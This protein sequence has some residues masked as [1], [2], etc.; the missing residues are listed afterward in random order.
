MLGLR[1]G[2][3]PCTIAT[4]TPRPIALL[5]KLIGGPRVAVTRGATA[6]NPN[7]PGAFLD[8]VREA[9]GGTRLA[10]QELDGELIEDADGTLWPRTLIEKSRTRPFDPGG[11]AADR[12]LRRIVV[13]V[14]PPAGA[15]EGADACGI[16]AVGLGS[17]GLGYVLADASVQGKGPEGWAAAVSRAASLWGADRV[18]A[19]ANNGG[20]MVESVLRACDAGLPVRRVHASRGKV[21]RAEPVAALFEKG[22]AKFAGAFPELEDELA[23]LTRGGEYQG[24]GRSPDRAD[25]MVWALTELMLGS[26][27]RV[28]RVRSL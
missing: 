21:A 2:A 13:G 16:V 25:A 15:G 7:L 19:E 27:A 6:D 26:T 1:L 3:A 22:R 14:D 9:Y 17:D 11:L 4:T 8:A 28:P 20:A 23:G 24:P 18:V 5:K 10:R 12:S